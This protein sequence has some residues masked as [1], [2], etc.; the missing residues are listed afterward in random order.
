MLPS[1]IFGHMSCN[2]MLLVCLFAFSSFRVVRDIKIFDRSTIDHFG[3]NISNHT[4]GV[5]INLFWVFKATIAKRR[6]LEITFV[7]AKKVTYLLKSALEI[8]FFNWNN[9]L[10]ILGI[11]FGVTDNLVK[12][13]GVSS[14]QSSFPMWFS[15]TKVLNCGYTFATW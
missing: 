3:I 8:F 15:H 13:H 7:V 2:I 9:I 10:L 12:S 11:C 1:C 4:L 14:V 5:L 6:H